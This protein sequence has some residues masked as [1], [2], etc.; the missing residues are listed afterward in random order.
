MRGVLVIALVALSSVAAN[1]QMIEITPEIFQKVRGL[2][3]QAKEKH[4][5]SPNDA[6][7]L[8]QQLFNGE[9]GDTRPSLIQVVKYQ[10][11]I[12]VEIVTPINQLFLEFATALRKLEPLIEEPRPATVAVMVNPKRVDAP[13]ISR[14][15][16]FVDGKEV[17]PVTS[18]LKPTEFRNGLGNAFQKGAGLVAWKPEAFTTGK[19]KLVCITDGTPIEWQYE[20]GLLGPQLK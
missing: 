6:F 1:A 13:D 11:S 12:D 20:P 2:A 7:Y 17:Q 9:F 5:T 14:I 18:S 10:P 8:F 16:L 15:V 3:S 4:P 19:V